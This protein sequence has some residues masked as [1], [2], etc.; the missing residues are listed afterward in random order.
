MAR[1]MI[2]AVMLVILGLALAATPASAQQT[3]NCRHRVRK[4]EAQLARAVR[5]HGKNSRQA[6]ARREHL[7]RVRRSCGL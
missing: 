2:S 7:E 5:R 6:A 4:A 3:G 1:K